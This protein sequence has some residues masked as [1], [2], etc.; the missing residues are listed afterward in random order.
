MYFY[1]KGNIMIL[2]SIYDEKTLTEKVWYDSSSVFYSE[3][4]EHPND[5]FGE[6]YVT[7]KGGGT[8]HYI[9]V[10]MLHDYILFKNGGSYGSQGKAINEFIKKKYEF[11]K[12]ENRDINLLT[13]ERDRTVD[14]KE[15]KL[16]T[17]FI[18]GH[19]NITPEQFERYRMEI[20]SIYVTDNEARFIVGD[21]CGVDIMAQDFLLDVLNIEPERVTVYHMFDKPRNVNTKVINFKGGFINDSERDAAMTNAS[22]KDI[23]FVADNKI[24]S[25]TAENILRRFLL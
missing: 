13:E 24:M 6:L 8:Y 9:N 22:F 3:F 16:H 20:H 12:C 18:S 2:K 25:G 17:Y 23:A 4:I 14:D 11:E 5:N 10:D 19:R 15:M 21:Y 1:K 7:F